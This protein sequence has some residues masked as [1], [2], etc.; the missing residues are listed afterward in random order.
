MKTLNFIPV[1]LA[2]LVLFLVRFG[3]AND[4]KYE[5]AMKKNIESVYK[6]QSIDELQ[7]AVNAFERIGNAEKKYWEP[8]YYAAF[9]YLMM[10]TKEKD[11]AKKDQFLDQ[12]AAALEKAKGIVTAESEVVALEG[13]IHMIRVTVDPAS[14]GA[15]YAGLAMQTFGK[16]IE[17]NP[18]NPRALY[19]MAQMQYGTAQFFGS[20]TVEA[21]GTLTKALEKF[22]TFKSENVLAPQWGKTSATSMKAQCQ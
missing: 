7:H 20:S 16:A 2:I 15:Q 8:H 21:C 13:F 17:L 3:F 14:R 1:L 5:Q 10:A 19:L 4:S 22:D 9:G 12:A 6:A 18:E 11:G